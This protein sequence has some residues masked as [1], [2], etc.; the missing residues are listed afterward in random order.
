MAIEIENFKSRLKIR[1]LFV[2]NSQ[3]REWI[4]QSRLTLLK[5]GLNISS[6][7]IE[8]IHTINRDYCFFF[9]RWALRDF[10]IFHRK[11]STEKLPS[12]IHDN[13]VAHYLTICILVLCDTP[14]CL[15][16]C[17]C[18]AN[19]L[20]ERKHIN[21]IPGILKKIVG[22]VPGQCPE[23]VVDM[24]FFSFLIF[25]VAFFLRL[26][27]VLGVPR[28]EKP[29]LCWGKPLLFP[30]KQGLE[31]QGSLWEQKS[32]T[33]RIGRQK[34][35]SLI[36]SVWLVL[37]TSRQ[38]SEQIGESRGIPENKERKSGKKGEIGTNRG[39]TFLATLCSSQMRSF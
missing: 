26:P 37:K 17:V 18:V 5:P 14:Y 31:G 3:G 16:V 15:C 38:K 25:L 11:K 8:K 6:A 7:W 21:K 29:L 4:L 1:P 22:M 20:E 28:R 13:L 19:F 12:K 30:K 36:C 9:N 10:F 2:W 33:C 24:F 34:G 23:N 39:D 32:G 27:R 35:L